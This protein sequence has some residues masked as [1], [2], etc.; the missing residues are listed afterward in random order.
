[1]NVTVT[2]ST[3]TRVKSQKTLTVEVRPSEDP[4]A[5]EIQFA[6]DVYAGEATVLK[7]TATGGSAPYKYQFTAKIDGK[8]TTLHN[9][10]E[11]ECTYTFEKAGSYPVNVTVTDSAGTRVKSQKTLWV[12]EP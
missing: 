2:D 12:L 11:S 3:G 4:L 5:A 10:T 1:M 8:W 7:A 6:E 9:G